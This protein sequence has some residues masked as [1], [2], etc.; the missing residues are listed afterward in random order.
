[1]EDEMIN[2]HAGQLTYGALIEL[3]HGNHVTK[4]TSLLTS[5][6]VVLLLIKH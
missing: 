6:M 2:I 1:M 4:S 3:L 5:T